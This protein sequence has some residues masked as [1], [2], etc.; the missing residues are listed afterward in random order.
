MLNSILFSK[1]FLNLF[2][3]VGNIEFEALLFRY[4]LGIKLLLG[5]FIYIY[6]SLSYA[7]FICIL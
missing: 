7:F 6:S 5:E 3:V 1:L 2:H 4:L